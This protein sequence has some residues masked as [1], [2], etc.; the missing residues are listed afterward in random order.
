[1]YDYR[2]PLITAATAALLSAIADAQAQ[3]VNAPLQRPAPQFSCAFVT[4]PLDCGF[5]YQAKA[6]GR[7]TLV[8][9]GREGGYAV[10]LRT[11]PGDNHVH[12]SG[13][14]WFSISRRL[15]PSM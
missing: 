11:H 9:P 13:P 1:M 3:D 4:S 12:G 10:R 15:R 7:A 2:L 14:A 8:R 6:P 5:Y